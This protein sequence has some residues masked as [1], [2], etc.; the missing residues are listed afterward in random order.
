MR[1]P[2][3][4]RKEAERSSALVEHQHSGAIGFWNSSRELA[5]STIQD[6]RVICRSETVRARLIYG[7]DSM[8]PSALQFAIFLFLASFNAGTMTT[9]QIQHY[10]LYPQVGREGFAAYVQANNKAAL[11]PAILPALLL[12]VT[13]MTLLVERPRFMSGA[14]AF[15][16]FVL[17]LIAL[18]SS[19]LWQ[20]RLQSE[21]AETGYDEQ[22]VRRLISTNW[23]RT[24]AFLIQGLLASAVTLRAIQMIR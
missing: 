8:D 10:A 11:V 4:L 15:A 6:S 20:R 7:A 12:L 24:G 3:L 1:S 13:S 17:N 18:A 22:K 14:E 5:T 16:V 19:F 23:I 21:M 9:L 2:K